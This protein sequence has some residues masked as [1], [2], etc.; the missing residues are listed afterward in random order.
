MGLA[1]RVKVYPERENR[2]AW[3]VLKAFCHLFAA[4]LGCKDETGRNLRSRMR[5]E[6]TSKTKHNFLCGASAR[7]TRKDTTQEDLTQQLYTR[8]LTAELS[9]RATKSSEFTRRAR[10]PAP[11]TENDA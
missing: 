4:I 11:A 7:E 2:C 6:G 8:A 3:A 9:R 5:Y 10:F 1:C